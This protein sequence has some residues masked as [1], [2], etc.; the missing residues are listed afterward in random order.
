MLLVGAAY[1][2]GALPLPAATIEQAI[3]LN[4]VAADRN[5]QA[6]RRGRQAVAD[7]RALAPQPPAVALAPAVPGRRADRRPR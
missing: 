1:Q 3:T 2:G 4:G 6:F 5:I 7:P